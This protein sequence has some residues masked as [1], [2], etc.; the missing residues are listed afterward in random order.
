MLG[1]VERGTGGGPGVMKF[2]GPVVHPNGMPAVEAMVDMATMCGAGGMDHWGVEVTMVVGIGG[3]AGMPVK[4]SVEGRGSS[5]EGGTAAPKGRW[6]T[7][8]RYSDGRCRMGKEKE[9]PASNDWLSLSF[10]RLVK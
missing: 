8:G 4:S 6:L 5:I 7:E 2:G 1:F 10:S 9:D 3:I